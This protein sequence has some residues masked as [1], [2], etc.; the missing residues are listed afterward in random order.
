MDTHSDSGGWE[1]LGY[2]I[3]PETVSDLDMDYEEE[4]KART[5]GSWVLVIKKQEADKLVSELVATAKQEGVRETVKH[6]KDNMGI[7]LSSD[8]DGN[9]VA[10][11][12]PVKFSAML[13]DLLSKLN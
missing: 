2:R 7:F 13:D 6:I 3:P 1:E 9:V 4:Q 5:D 10:L 12:D 11:Y 8:K